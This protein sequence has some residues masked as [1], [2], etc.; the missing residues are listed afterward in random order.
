[1]TLNGGKSGGTQSD[2][3]VTEARRSFPKGCS[4]RSL[5][6]TERRLATVKP[7]PVE[8]P[9]RRRPWSGKRVEEEE[10]MLLTTGNGAKCGQ[11]RRR[12]R[13]CVQT[14]EPTK[15]SQAWHGPAQPRPARLTTPSA[16]KPSPPTH[17]NPGLPPSHPQAP[18][19]VWLRVAACGCMWLRVAPGGC[20]WLRVVAC[21]CMWLR[22][23]ACRCL[24]VA[25]CGCVNAI[26]SCVKHHH[27]H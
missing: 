17:N 14:S 20:I 22:V 3:R 23:A 21:G 9:S 2:A 26:C 10:E 1:V 4:T 15:L 5:Y 24:H 11:V 25:A 19:C 8:M 12:T 13:S 6:R 7:R 18:C 16:T 27:P